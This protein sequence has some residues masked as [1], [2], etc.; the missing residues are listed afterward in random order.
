M[1]LKELFISGTNNT[2]I[3]FFR[4]LFVGGIATVADMAVLIFFLIAHILFIGKIR[5][6]YRE[7]HLEEVK[8]AGPGMQRPVLAD[9]VQRELGEQPDDSQA[10]ESEETWE[11]EEDELVSEPAD[12][13][14]ADKA[15]D[16]RI[17]G[18]RYRRIETETDEEEP[19]SGDLLEIAKLFKKK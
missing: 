7:Y 11:A 12:A 9:Y 4:S 2:F 18:R 19:D 5:A 14:D 3:Q 8:D 10:E 6:A 17:A 13:D 16:R 15:E 1:K